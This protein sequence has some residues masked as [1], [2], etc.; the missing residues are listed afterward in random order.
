MPPLTTHY[1][2]LQIS[3][4]ADA[5]VVRAAY[6]A[7]CQTNHPD[8]NLDDP[9]RANTRMKRINEAYGVLS[10]KARRDAYDM[11]LAS[12]ESNRQTAKKGRYRNNANPDGKRPEAKKREAGKSSGEKKT[13]RP[14]EAEAP[15]YWRVQAEK[16]HQSTGCGVPLVF[17]EDVYSRT[18][19]CRSCGFEGTIRDPLG[20]PL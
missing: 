10:D 5:T 18:Y 14:E 1:D 15:D 13:Q 17:S 11:T 2:T 19:A 20:R 4:S 9:E 6:R 8:K 7:L 12:Q 16:N 3:R